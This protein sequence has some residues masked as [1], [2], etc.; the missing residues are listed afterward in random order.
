MKCPVCNHEMN[1]SMVNFPIKIGNIEKS[2]QIFSHVC[3][4]C[5]YDEND[6]RNKGLISSAINDALV[7]CSNA[8][9]KLWKKQNRSCFSYRWNR[10]R[11]I[12][13]ELR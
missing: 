2:T 7:S 6:K 3:H 5:G 10:F 9:L 8:I 11:N 1:E 4:E 13:C 12:R